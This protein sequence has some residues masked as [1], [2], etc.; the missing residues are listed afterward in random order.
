MFKVDN[1][2]QEKEKPKRNNICFIMSR[3]LYLYGIFDLN[4]ILILM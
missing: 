1:K 2:K 4:Q 3:V